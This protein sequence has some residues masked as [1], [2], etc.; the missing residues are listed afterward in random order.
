MNKKELVTSSTALEQ[1]RDLLLLQRG[2]LLLSFVEAAAAK[3]A[4]QDGPSVPAPQANQ[5]LLELFGAN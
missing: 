1:E 2:E 4:Q 3:K 5:R